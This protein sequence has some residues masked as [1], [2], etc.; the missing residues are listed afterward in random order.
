MILKF[1]DLIMNKEV[2]INEIINFFEKNYFFKFENKN[3]KI[4]NMIDSTK[5]LK[6]KKEEE[7]KGFQESVSNNSFFSVGKKNQWKSILDNE[8]TEKIEQK[9]SKVMKNFNYT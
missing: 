4:Q 1:E 5:F 2:V 9:F 6:F 8:Q 7:Q 3:E